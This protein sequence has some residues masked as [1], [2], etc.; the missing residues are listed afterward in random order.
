MSQQLQS[1]CRSYKCDDLQITGWDK[2]EVLLPLHSGFINTVTF[3]K[4]RGLEEA[5]GSWSQNAKEKSRFHTVCWTY[6]CF[7]FPTQLKYC[8][9]FS[10]CLV[11]SEIHKDEVGSKKHTEQPCLNIF[12]HL[13]LFTIV[14]FF[15]F[16]SYKMNK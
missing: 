7:F 15:L 12:F 5:V 4:F 14:D 10:I 13:I 6:L 3:Q 9:D 11:F 1:N 16:S 8:H 2:D